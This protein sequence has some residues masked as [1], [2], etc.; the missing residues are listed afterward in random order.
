MVP[1][2]VGGFGDIEKA[3]KV[4]Y[5]NEIV[6]YQNLLEQINERLG[7]EVIRFKEYKLLLP[8]N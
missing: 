1:Q 6:F 2:N 4:F 7:I 8:S 5:N 3:A